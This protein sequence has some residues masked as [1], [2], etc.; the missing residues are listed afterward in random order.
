MKLTEIG[1][2]NRQGNGKIQKLSDGGGLI[3]YITPDGKKSWRLLYRY[4]GKQKT[5]S[6]GIYP[7]V[8]LKEAR[9]KRDEA[10]KML[11]NN[12]DPSTA[13]KEAKR[14]AAISLQNTYKDI[15]LEWLEKQRSK[16]VP[17]YLS[18]IEQRQIKFVIPFLGKAVI[19]TIKPLDL[20]AVCRKVEESG[21]IFLAHLIMR[22]CGRVFR[23]AVATGR[24]ERDISVDLKGALSPVPPTQHMKT[25]RDHD[26]IGEML[27][28]FES[29]VGSFPMK[30][31][32]RLA[33]YVF[34]RANELVA[35]EWSE[36][37][38]A[39]AE[40]RI[41]AHKMKMKQVHIVPLSRQAISIL[42]DAEALSR[43]Q[44]YVFPGFGHAGHYYDRYISKSGILCALKNLGYGDKMCIHG[45]RSM[46]ST[47][48]NEQGY[49]WDWIERQLA[50][51]ERNQVRAAY[52]YAQYLPER[53]R[54]MQEY[55]DYLDSLRENARARKEA[56]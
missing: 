45:F 46:A 13:K 10:K 31:A 27:L 28:S 11:A 55:A 19:D 2:R 20:L 23:Y 22:E 24:A 43:G 56:A 42:H 8:G 25:I 34:V 15:S 5:L 30:C 49:Q 54:M 9:D 1:I 18:A 53:R 37:D 12:I 40:W 3:L 4:L 35:A 33:P 44:K 47:I 50:H 41:P 17:R 29:Y 52:N 21:R 6:I 38:F 39:N 36:I 48:L 26:N 7:A 32:L 51:T 14:Q 16:L